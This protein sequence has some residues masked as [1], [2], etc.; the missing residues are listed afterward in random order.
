MPIE[1]FATNRT[2]STRSISTV[3]VWTWLLGPTENP[4]GRKNISS[5]TRRFPAPNHPGIVGA[6]FNDRRVA[7]G[8]HCEDDGTSRTNLGDARSQ[9]KDFGPNSSS[10]G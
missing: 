4:V 7:S 6:G 10:I 9:T 8:N 1:D 5:A 3:E 2:S